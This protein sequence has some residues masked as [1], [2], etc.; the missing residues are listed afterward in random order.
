MSDCKELKEKIEIS[1]RN[2]HLSNY[3]R[4]RKKE[5]KE[6]ETLDFDDNYTYDVEEPEK[7]DARSHQELEDLQ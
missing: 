4:A 1:W 5:K 6:E 3:K 2:D 7:Y